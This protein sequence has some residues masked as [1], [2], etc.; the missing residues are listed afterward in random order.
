MVEGPGEINLSLIGLVIDTLHYNVL[1][2]QTAVAT[3]EA[4]GLASLPSYSK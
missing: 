4:W 1:G 3:A 2:V